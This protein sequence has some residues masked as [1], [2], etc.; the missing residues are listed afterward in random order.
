[1][2]AVIHYCCLFTV[3]VIL[4]LMKTCV[5]VNWGPRIF[6]PI[7]FIFFMVLQVSTAYVSNDS[8]LAERM[9]LDSIFIQVVNFYV[10][11]VS[12]L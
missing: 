2:H 12:V 9:H 11:N 8:I 6:F 3:I 1:M 5:N 7:Y 4:G 10:I